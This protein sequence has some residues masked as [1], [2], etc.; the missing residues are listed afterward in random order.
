MKSH[1]FKII[2]L[3]ITLQNG[4]PVFLQSRYRVIKNVQLSWNFTKQNL[5]DSFTSRSKLN[6]LA[7]CNILN[8]KCVM[9]SITDQICNLFGSAA[10]EY[11]MVFNGTEN[12]ELFKK[13]ERNCSSYQFYDGTSCCRFFFN[14]IGGSIAN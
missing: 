10:S 14:S 2:C 12:N 1:F 5:L 7:E 9:V 4:F 3:L 6:C 11:E 8:R 13:L